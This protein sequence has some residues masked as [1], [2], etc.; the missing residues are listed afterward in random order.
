VSGWP[1]MMTNVGGIEFEPSGLLF[2]RR[3]TLTVTPKRIDPKFVPILYGSDAGGFDAYLTPFTRAGNSYRLPLWHFS[4]I[5]DGVVERRLMDEFFIGIEKVRADNIENR[6]RHALEV[7]RQKQLAGLPGGES[8]SEITSALLARYDKEVVQ[9]KI[10][11]MLEPGATCLRAM[12]TIRTM[13]G[14]ERK[15]Q[16]L[17]APDDSGADDAKN[18][19]VKNMYV[20]TVQWRDKERTIPSIMAEICK[21]E[22]RKICAESG[23]PTQVAATSFGMERSLQL[24]GSADD[25]SRF[26][27]P[28]EIYNIAVALQQC[29]RYDVLFESIQDGVHT[30]L[31]K[32]TQPV[33]LEVRV[34]ATVSIPRDTLTKFSKGEIDVTELD[35]TAEG[36]GEHLVTGYRHSLKCATS[37]AARLD[38]AQEILATSKTPLKIRL[39]PMN[40]PRIWVPRPGET[41]SVFGFRLLLDPGEV[42]LNWKLW[43][44]FAS[45]IPAESSEW[46]SK[47][48]LAAHRAHVANGKLQY[49]PPEGGWI[50]ELNES[51]TWSSGGIWNGTERTRITIT[52][53]PDT[54]LPAKDPLDIPPGVTPDK[55]EQTPPR[56][57]LRSRP[58]A[59]PR[60]Q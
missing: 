15:S 33:K 55:P 52:Y 57:P 35:L 43:T 54:S 45:N 8:L 4:G 5:G 41:K 38:G 12:D 37:L 48:F 11:A 19:N 13:L 42:N 21:E 23:D 58:V 53:A 3:A 7:E 27:N 9:P 50:I 29:A 51:G 16:L 60:A 20:R 2:S 1:N 36:E 34:R 22:S 46:W 28:T 26:L 18:I 56:V 24:L 32:C 39:T 31:A 40:I 10:A 30:D 14:A 49:T 47:G 17:G 59:P 44:Y 25:E 6:I